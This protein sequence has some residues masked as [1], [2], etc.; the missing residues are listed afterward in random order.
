M[1]N[2]SSLLKLSE[3]VTTNPATKTNRQIVPDKIQSCYQNDS[4]QD[5]TVVTTATTT[6]TKIKPRLDYLPCSILETN[7]TNK[8][9]MAATPSMPSHISNSNMDNL[10][11]DDDDKVPMVYNTNFKVPDLIAAKVTK[12]A[13]LRNQPFVE[14]PPECKMVESEE[15]LLKK[16][17][18]V[19][20]EKW[21]QQ[22]SLAR[23]H[24]KLGLPVRKEN[25]SEDQMEKLKMMFINFIK[26][27]MDLKEKSPFLKILFGSTKDQP[28]EAI[29]IMQFLYYAD[30]NMSDQDFVHIA[31]LI[32]KEPNLGGWC[33]DI[34]KDSNDH[35]DVI[36]ECV[37]CH[38]EKFMFIVSN[39]EKK[40]FITNVLFC[41]ATDYKQGFVELQKHLLS[42][43]KHGKA[44]HGITLAHSI[45]LHNLIELTLFGRYGSSRSTKLIEAWIKGLK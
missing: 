2:R 13:F 1:V 30:V 42:V 31:D 40:Q 18:Q 4:Q 20:K 44:M 7:L 33:C 21:I 16:V 26:S 10:P 39:K 8:S 43:A 27:V 17:K 29:I 15:A 35:H 32:A 11:D 23:I 45:Y 36:I 3:T 24:H 12:G 41:G 6:K 28:D 22:Y 37:L 9:N 25:M 14:P 5:T 34:L 19:H 38:L